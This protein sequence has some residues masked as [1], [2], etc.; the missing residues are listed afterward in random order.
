MHLNE[1]NKQCKGVMRFLACTAA[2]RW[3]GVWVCD[4]CGATIRGTQKALFN[5]KLNADNSGQSDDVRQSLNIPS[6]EPV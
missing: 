4:Y 3:P 6:S 1:K 2:D 5:Y